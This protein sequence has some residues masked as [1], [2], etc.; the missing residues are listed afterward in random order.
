MDLGYSGLRGRLSALGWVMAI[1]CGPGDRRQADLQLDVAGASLI[2]T[3][4]IRVCVEDALIHETPLGDGRVA[5]PGLPAE[6]A[7]QV[8]VHAIS[9]EESSGK[10][11]PTLLDTQTPWAEVN[12]NTC[13]T[14]CTPCN[15]EKR[16]DQKSVDSERLL[17]IHFID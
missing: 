13:S 16:S 15:I 3:D 11:E 2:D 1:G 10:T 6:G 4:W 17:S 7:L 12:W 8:S 9:A 14:P 5:I